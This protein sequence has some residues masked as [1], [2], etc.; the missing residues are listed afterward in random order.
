[1]QQILS[2]LVNFRMWG[3]HTSTFWRQEWLLLILLNLQTVCQNHDLWRV[4]HFCRNLADHFKIEFPD[5][6][7]YSCNPC[8][9]TPE[10]GV[11]ETK[12]LFWTENFFLTTTEKSLTRMDSLI[13]SVESTRESRWQWLSDCRIC[14]CIWYIPSVIR[15]RSLKADQRQSMNEVERNQKNCTFLLCDPCTSLLEDWVSGVNCL[16]VKKEA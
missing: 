10:S 1:M 6:E 16:F 12:W 8:S 5:S 15:E 13:L 9:F 3:H 11:K 2:C 4:F 7:T 14:W